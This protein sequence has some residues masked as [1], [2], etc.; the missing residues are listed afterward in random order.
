VLFFLFLCLQQ[1]GDNGELMPLPRLAFVPLSSLGF[2]QHWREMIALYRKVTAVC[3]VNQDGAEAPIGQA[4]E[5]AVRYWNA[6]NSVTDRIRFVWFD[7]HK[8]CDKKSGGYE[9]VQPLVERLLVADALFY[10][11][12]GSVLQEGVVRTNCIDNLDR[13]NVVQSEIARYLLERMIEKVGGD[14]SVSETLDSRFK[15]VWADHADMISVRY[16]GVGA[17]KVV[18]GVF[19]FLMCVVTKRMYQT[20]YT[21]TGKRSGKGMAQDAIKSVQR[22]AQHHFNDS[23][24][25]NFTELLL[26]LQTSVS[27]NMPERTATNSFCACLKE[28]SASAQVCFKKRIFLSLIFL[29]FLQP[30]QKGSTQEWVHAVGAGLLVLE[31]RADGSLRIFSPSLLLESNHPRDCLLAAAPLAARGV[32]VFWRD[33]PEPFKCFFFS[34]HVRDRFLLLA[35]NPPRLL[36]DLCAPSSM[37]SLGVLL[38]WWPR[39][40]FADR[41]PGGESVAAFARRLFGSFPQPSGVACLAL[42]DVLAAAAPNDDAQVESEGFS[43]AHYAILLFSIFLGPSF[44]LVQIAAGASERVSLAVWLHV[45]LMPRFVAT[46]TC[47]V[48]PSTSGKK[49]SKPTLVTRVKAQISGPSEDSSVVPDSVGCAAKLVLS[50]CRPLIFVATSDAAGAESLMF[51]GAHVGAHFSS[52]NL[53]EPSS[54]TF[55][56]GSDVLSFPVSAF[57]GLAAFPGS[58]Y[59]VGRCAGMDSLLSS[60]PFHASSSATVA[61]KQSLPTVCCVCV[62]T[63]LPGPAPLYLML[64]VWEARAPALFCSDAVVLQLSRAG[65]LVRSSASRSPASWPAPLELRLASGFCDIDVA[66]LR[67]TENHAVVA[68]GGFS[69]ALIASDATVTREIDMI[70]ASSALAPWKLSFTL[71]WS[72]CN[73][74]PAAVDPVMQL[75]GREVKV[76]Q[77]TAGAPPVPPR[78]KK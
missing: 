28:P 30:T 74:Q 19:A 78:P 20:D 66:V 69:I 18:F 76:V 24:K 75:L 5:R 36:S 55:W 6:T 61:V 59:I 25:M 40:S 47:Q 49:V 52:F 1:R 15:H 64:T 70:D 35:N 46:H 37:P 3:L 14:A 42:E 45:S 2:D 53:V 11:S 68:T 13:T 7:F 67:G 54:N 58:G 48:A 44:E 63:M 27:R 50:S 77:Q 39:L 71:R 31:V 60:H 22:L 9:N 34:E 43:G 17:L 57:D 4:Y 72:Y 23:T 26:G 12:D 29:L 33:R 62:P 10:S 56:M 38:L 16:T 32:R 41:A 73:P 65:V 8:S 21:R 51:A